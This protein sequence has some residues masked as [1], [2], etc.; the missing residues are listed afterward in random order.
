MSTDRKSE[1][2]ETATSLFYEKGYDNT[3][4]RD[5]AKQAGLSN[6]GVYYFFHNKEEILF[7]IIDS[8]VSKFYQTVSESID[9]NNE[10]EENLDK[11]INSSLHVVV[12]QKR[13]IGLSN[14]ESKRLSPEQLDIINYKKRRIYELIKHEFTRIKEKGGLTDISPGYASF[15]L[16]LIIQEFSQWY[17]PEG[18]TTIQ[19]FTE[20]TKAFFSI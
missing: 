5:L 11:I 1:V 14:T 16:T 9:P 13:E 7:T 18:K 15:I 10:P 12:N 8:A 4:T 3:S 17:N 19:E 6:A 20:Q 2:L